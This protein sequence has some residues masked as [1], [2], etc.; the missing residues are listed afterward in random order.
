[1]RYLLDSSAILSHHRKEPGW[2]Q[3]HSLMEDA[4]AEITTASVCLAE[5]ARRLHDLGATEEQALADVTAY[6]TLMDKVIPIDATVARSALALGQ[7]SPERLPL[8][9]AL[10][11]AAAQT[12]DAILVHRD[13]HFCHIP[14]HLMRQQYL[15]G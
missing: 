1:M 6:E 8:V 10:I 11:A 15:A 13:Q 12:H 14:T 4:A 5:L 3:V 7:A 9:D 2:E